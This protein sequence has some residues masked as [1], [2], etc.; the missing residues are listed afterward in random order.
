MKKSEICFFFAGC[1]SVCRFGGRSLALVEESPARGTGA[2]T[3]SGVGNG[4]GG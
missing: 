3:A 1:I 4:A 2:G